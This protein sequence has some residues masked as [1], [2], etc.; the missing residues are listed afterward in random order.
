[1]IPCP[2]AWR[3]YFFENHWIESIDDELAVFPAMVRVKSGK[4]Q[5]YWDFS[6]DMKGGTAAQERKA[7]EEVRR[8]AWHVFIFLGS[9]AARYLGVRKNWTIHH[10]LLDGNEILL[11][12]QVLYSCSLLQPIQSIELYFCHS[13]SQSIE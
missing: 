4:P 1:M 7:I 10:C 11:I 12:F 3:P 13:Q 6:K 5:N 9:P 8:A 2:E